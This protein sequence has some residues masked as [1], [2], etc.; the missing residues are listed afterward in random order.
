MRRL[1]LSLSV[2]LFLLAI[3]SWPLLG[4][5]SG[6]SWPLLA[7]L[8]LG[9][10]GLVLRETRGARVLA[11]ALFG[12]LAFGLAFPVLAVNLFSVY[13]FTG[14]AGPMFFGVPAA[15]F[16]IWSAFL[17]L[18]LALGDHLRWRQACMTGVLPGPWV[19]GLLLGFME[20]LWD[21][22]LLYEGILWAKIPSLGAYPMGFVPGF[23]TFHIFVGWLFAALVDR[24]NAA[25]CSRPGHALKAASLMTLGGLLLL[26]PSQFSSPPQL[27]IPGPLL[28]LLDLGISCLVD[29]L[30][31]L[32]V[33]K[34]TPRWLPRRRG[35]VLLSTNTVPVLS[36]PG[37]I[38][39]LD[40][41]ASRLSR[42]QGVWTNES[43][44]PYLGSHILAANLEA[45]CVVLEYPTLEEF[46]E[47]LRETQPEVVG[48]GFSMVARSLVLEMC[49]ATR[50][51]APK[52]LIV[53]GGHG[54]VCLQEKDK[55]DEEFEG[56]VDELCHGEGVAF[57]R[58]LLGQPVESPLNLGL[59]Y[60][61]LYPMG[62]RVPAYR[63]APLVTG[64]GCDR[65]CDFCGTSA[66]FGG[67]NIRFGSAEEIYQRVKSALLKDPDLASI[68]ILDEDYLSDQERAREVARR[69]REDP[70]VD[71]S[72]IYFSVFSSIESVAAY[73]PEE[74]QSLGMSFMWIG[75]ESKFTPLT[76]CTRHDVKAVLQGLSDVG[77]CVTLSWVMGFDF[78]TP[79]NIEEDMDWYLELP[80]V[81]A[82]VT[83][84]GP[85]PG[86]VVYRRLEAE[87]RLKVDR[88]EDL[89]LYH[90]CFEYKNFPP[91]ELEK[92][93]FKVYDQIHRRK[94]PSILR[95]AESWTA[96]IRTLRA[97]QAPSLKPRIE[98]LVRN[99]QEMFPVAY[100]MERVGYEPAHQT[101][102]RKWIQDMAALGFRPRPFDPLAGLA[103]A[104][105]LRV[106]RWFEDHFGLVDRQPRTIRTF[107][108]QGRPID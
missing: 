108:H 28:F 57:M 99:A 49:R 40:F 53:L 35:R 80:A 11:Q 16:L 34:F 7:L 8:I 86:T 54:V 41:Y 17:L 25:G 1:A 72:R 56:L 19:T 30:V 93:V 12:S 10:S 21:P 103:L 33:L 92:W 58:E 63:M 31:L 15:T 60:Q 44:A 85:I 32:L 23:V 37:G 59:P 84:L 66:F 9:G 61:E 100:A 38:Y 79:E 73:T 106:I 98:S 36:Y 102:A 90:E 97:T 22:A 87:G 39:P 5:P 94:G 104:G 20:L 4:I 52:A 70:E 29:G 101:R 46:C 77:I 83:L 26:L 76:K 47:E 68:A 64:F 24:L 18:A 62:F 78:Q 14:K 89:N 50:K 67:K 96:G 82:Q 45:E 13:G 105:L 2:C 3:L 43:E 55:L 69:L 88:W 48:I 91:G 65:R 74:L 107:Y 71:F 51:L 95:M 75:A 81:T 27:E 6:K 42:G